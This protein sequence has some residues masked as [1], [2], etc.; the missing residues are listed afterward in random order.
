MECF[1][2]LDAENDSFEK[3]YDKVAWRLGPGCLIQVIDY[4]KEMKV[5]HRDLE[6]ANILVKSGEALIADFSVSKDPIDGETTASLT[7]AVGVGMLMY[8]APEV[9][10]TSSTARRGRAV[11]IF[12]LGCIFLELTTLGL[13][14]GGS[15][16]IRRIRHI[17]GLRAFG[18]CLQKF[19]QWIISLLTWNSSSPKECFVSIEI[20]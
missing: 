5:K 9:V 19:L 10:L 8:W 11:G 14:G 20:N 3:Q 4:F 17:D 1:D 15:L 13:A 2:H 16:S 18:Q 6:L 12:A 7:H